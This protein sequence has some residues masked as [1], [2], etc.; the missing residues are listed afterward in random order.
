MSSASSLNSALASTTATTG[1]DVSTILAALVGSASPGI[2]VTS[3]VNSALYADRATERVWQSEQTTLSSQMTGLQAMQASASTLQTDMSNLNSLTGPLS[4]RVVT[5][6]DPAAVTA[7]AASGTTI[8][9]HQVSVNNLA[10]TAS[11]Y[12]AS[13]SSPS[14]T[15]PAGSF[16]LSMNGGTSATFTPGSGNDATLTS[17]ASDING[18]S[19]G[20]TAS[21]VTDSTGSRLS[22]VSN[23]SGAANGFAVGS[24]SGLT[25]TQA[26]S[27]ADASLTVDG[28]PIT[29]A[30]NVVTGALSGVTLDL[31]SPTAPSVPVGLSVASDTTQTSNAINQLVSDYN[32]AA[33]LLN[34]QFTFSASTSTEGILASDPTVQALQQTMQSIASYTG[35]SSGTGVN[36]LSDLGISLN[37]DGTLTA[38]AATLDGVLANN[39]SGVQQFMQ[40]SA[41]NGFAA[42]ASNALTSF[43]DPS[44]GA[45]TVDINSLN[46]QN[47]DLTTQISNFESG[48]IAQQQTTLTTDFTNAESALQNLPTELAQIQAELGNAPRTNNG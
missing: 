24:A 9:N 44:I 35:S 37:N 38:D 20:V 4:A 15:L 16:T 7:T 41:L 32:S 8:G 43:S 36:S 17:L 23:S 11:W 22:I 47:T 39:P 29:S 2:D 5:S 48:Y 31:L 30:S 26:S 25:F 46:N 34:Q 27:G 14:T 12:S 28:V 13:Q 21:I 3:A 42:T 6:S 45:F 33:S 10:T 18:Q 40:G 1:I 19:L